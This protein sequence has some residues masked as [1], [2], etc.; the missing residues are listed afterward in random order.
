M[1]KK[2]RG[3]GKGLSALIPDE[4]VEQKKEDNNKNSI[5]NIDI[6]LIEPNGGQPRKDFS[7]EALEELTRSIEKHGV[8]QPII[9]RKVDEGYQLVAG[10]RRW[11]ASKEAGL[12]EI[13]CIVK[14]IE[15]NKSTEIALIENIQREDLN[16]IEEALAYNNLIKE[17]NLTQEKIS[18]VVG[19]SRSYIANIMRLLNLSDEVIK[20]ISKG[21][22][23]SGHGRTLLGVK[24]EKEQI[25]L[26]KK[27]IENNLSVRETEK[28]V[29][30]LNKENDKSNTKKRNKDPILLELE[31]NLRKRFGTKVKINKKKNK[32]K[33]EIE[34]YSNEDL[35]RILEILA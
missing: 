21:K 13:P 19:K 18:E 7:S 5:I 27:V 10:E 17:Y 34:Y 24:N 30:N 14:D 1:A 6:A 11:R 32:G 12:K 23:S 22:L 35:E 29:K 20:L 25:E 9:V 8:I 2:K 3:L 4:P 16:S 33:I 26:A 31:E 15:Q 28:L